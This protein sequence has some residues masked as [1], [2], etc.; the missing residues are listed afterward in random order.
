MELTPEK[1]AVLQSLADLMHRKNSAELARH[2][3]ARRALEAELEDA[4]A[5]AGVTMTGSSEDT[6]AD[7]A[8]ARQW[9]ASSAPVTRAL[10]ARVPG[11][12]TDIAQARDLFLRRAS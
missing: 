4:R 1:L 12:E 9:A 2:I 7:L 10:L 3:Q 8:A 5:R 11:L 6:V